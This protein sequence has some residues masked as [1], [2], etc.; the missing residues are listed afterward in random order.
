MKVTIK[1]LTQ[2]KAWNALA[3]HHKKLE[4]LN[5]R[6]I[7]AD[8]LKR[9]ERLTVEAAGVFLDYSKNR[10][11]GETLK[12]L[13]ALARESGLRAAIRAMFRGEKINLTENRAVLHVALRAPK[14][15]SISV[16]G[17][18]V[19]PEVHA[20]LNKM[21]AFSRRI[22][23][24]AWKGHTGKRIRNVVNIGIGGSDLGPV[25]AY[26]ELK[27]YS[28]RA[29]TFRF[30]SNVDGTDLAE[31]T[32]DLDPAETLFIASSK[33]FTTVETMTTAET[34]RDWSLNGSAGDATAVAK[35][36]V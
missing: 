28:D 16:D 20:V 9:G 32:R 21:A 8:D 10:I 31:A 1:P 3:A 29:M 14:D 22:R 7:F 34:A 35:H 19:V 15:A 13:A 2:R 11:T 18:N 17:R 5:L 6:Q 24:G 12:L 36:F 23:S 26:E 27:H 33:T 30:V 4:K 25:M